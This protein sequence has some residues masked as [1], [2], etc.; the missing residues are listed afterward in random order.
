MAEK[1]L[2]EIWTTKDYRCCFGC[3][4]EN[5]FGLKIK[6][7]WNG[8]EGICRWQAKPYHKGI[9]GIL[10]GGIIATLI[11]CHSFW[12]GLAAIYQDQGIP[13]GEGEPIKMVTGAMAIRY[14]QPIPVDAEVELKA[15]L[16]KIGGRSRVVHCS[17]NVGGKE[18][19]QGEVTLVVV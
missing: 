7:F 11:D 14:L 4:P 13:F 15:R 16:T 17:V 9:Q 8:K 19:A 2:Q 6:S 10:N 5:N 12:T 1:S 18:Y 3:G